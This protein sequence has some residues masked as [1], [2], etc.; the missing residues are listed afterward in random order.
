MLEAGVC[1][2]PALGGNT[3]A[4]NNNPRTL[5]LCC[6]FSFTNTAALVR[7]ILREGKSSTFPPSSRLSFIAFCHIE[8]WWELFYNGIKK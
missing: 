2:H 4:L 7:I 3:L 1:F 6:C 5:N 8:L